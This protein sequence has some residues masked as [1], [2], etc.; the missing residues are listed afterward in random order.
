MAQMVG[1]ALTC[2]LALPLSTGARPRALNWRPDFKTWSANRVER[3]CTEDYELV[4]LEFSAAPSYRLIIWG[5]YSGHL[6][7]SAG[8]RSGVAY[9]VSLPPT[10]ANVVA[11]IDLSTR[12]GARAET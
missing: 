11:K 4:V 10:S 5:I 7:H 8:R 2:L 1:L 12:S 3:T 9:R 6:S